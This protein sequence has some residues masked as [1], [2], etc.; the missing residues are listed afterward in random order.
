MLVEDRLIVRPGA[1]L[2]RS[3]GDLSIGQ[4]VCGVRAEGGSVTFVVGPPAFPVDVAAYRGRP[5][6]GGHS[7]AECVWGLVQLAIWPG[8]ADPPALGG[9]PFDAGERS[10][11]GHG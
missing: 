9:E 3:A 1:G 8:V 5:R 2:E 11:A 7:G 10:F 6:F 4:P